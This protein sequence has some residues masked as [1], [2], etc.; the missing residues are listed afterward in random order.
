MQRGFRDSFGG[1]LGIEGRGAPLKSFIHRGR[2]LIRSRAE[3][4]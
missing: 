1:V 3:L 4:P 2:I